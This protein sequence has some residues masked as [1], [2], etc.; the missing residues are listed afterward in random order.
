VRVA[1]FGKVVLCQPLSN[2]VGRYANDG[3]LPR[4]EVLRELKEIHADRA[5]F[6]GAAWTMNRVFDDV[7]EEL[8]ASFARPK[9]SALHQPIELCQHGLLADFIE[10]CRWVPAHLACGKSY[11][12]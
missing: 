2:F 9:G 1:I 3:V 8:A 6:Q 7:L 5:F 12:T 11:H 4:V 10:F